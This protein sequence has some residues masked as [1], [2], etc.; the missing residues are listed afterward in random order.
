MFLVAGRLSLKRPQVSL[1]QVAGNQ[2]DTPADH[3]AGRVLPFQPF[4]MAK[5]FG[6]AAATMGC[7]GSEQAL[8]CWPE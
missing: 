4:S 3:F 6:F 1:R 2:T 8:H 5:V 7:V